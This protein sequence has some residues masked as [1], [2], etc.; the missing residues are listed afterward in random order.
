MTLKELEAMKAAET[1]VFDAMIEI[2]RILDKAKA[3]YKKAGGEREWDEVE[4]EIKE[5]V[6]EE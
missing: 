1:T 6:F 4:E 2:R 3:D 5:R